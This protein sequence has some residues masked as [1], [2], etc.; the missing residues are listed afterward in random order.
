MVTAGSGLDD[1][2]NRLGGFE[3]VEEPSERYNLYAVDL[4][5]IGTPAPPTAGTSPTVPQ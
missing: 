4:Q 5:K 2:L 3:P 1:G